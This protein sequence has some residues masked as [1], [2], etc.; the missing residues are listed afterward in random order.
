MDR[1]FE[2]GHFGAEKAAGVRVVRIAGH[3]GRFP[4]R[5]FHQQAA[6]VG[7]V[8]GADGALYFGGHGYLLAQ[9]KGFE[10]MI[11]RSTASPGNLC[12]RKARKVRKEN[13]K[14]IGF[15]LER[16]QLFPCACALKRYGAQVRP[17]RP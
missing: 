11:Q 10:V 14:R 6:G 1:L 7:A 16:F 15:N 13:L 8:V 3:P 17:L 2:V 9:Q 4:V 12:N 5:H